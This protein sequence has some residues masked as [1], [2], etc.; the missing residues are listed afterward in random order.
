MCINMMPRFLFL[1]LM[2]LFVSYQ[3]G[4][5][6]RIQNTAV[7]LVTLTR[8]RSHISPVLKK[9]HWLP[10][11][12]RI[13]YKILLNL[14]VFKA[15]NNLAPEYITQL[16]QPHNPPR[17]LRSTDKSL[18]SEPRSNRSFGDRSFSVAAPCLWNALPSHLKSISSLPQF[19]TAL[20]P[21]NPKST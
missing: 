7:H 20:N 17:I 8:K 16:L 6:Q 11:G 2:L 9:L 21:L 13:K 18:L 15:M 14:I 3:V 1:L 19:K 4:R 5:L 12:F 10:I